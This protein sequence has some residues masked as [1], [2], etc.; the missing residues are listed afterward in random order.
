[1]KIADVRLVDFEYV[2][3]AAIVREIMRRARQPAIQDRLVTVMVVGHPD[4]ELLLD[5]GQL[6]AICEAG[7]SKRLKKI[8]KDGGRG[9][10]RIAGASRLPQPRP[11]LEPLLKH[12]PGFACR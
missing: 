5:P 12:D 2:V 1:M 10:G 6:S 4:H 7:R 3:L 9:H 8:P 11:H